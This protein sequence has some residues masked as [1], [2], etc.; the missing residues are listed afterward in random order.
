[1]SDSCDLIDCCLPGFSVH[2]TL[3][4]RI[5][6]GLLFLSPGDLSNPGIKL[7][8]P[9]L[10]AESLPIE[11]PGKPFYIPL[12]KQVTWL[13]PKSRREEFTFP[14]ISHG[15]NVDAGREEDLDPNIQTIKYYTVSCFDNTRGH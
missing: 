15:K 4:A 1:M 13:S 8:S 6:G 12:A 10:Q 7:T 9:A 11:P 3:Q 2:G 14:R 5:L